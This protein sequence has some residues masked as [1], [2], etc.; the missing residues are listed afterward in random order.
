ME[1][2]S[3][4]EINPAAAGKGAETRTLHLAQV[5]KYGKAHSCFTASGREAI[6]LALCSLEAAQPELPKRC[7]LPAYLCDSVFLPFRH[8]GWELIFYTVDRGLMSYGEELFH[9]ALE[10]DPGMVLIHPYYGTDTCRELRVHLKA[11][12]KS[13]IYVMEDV[14]QSYYLEGVGKDVDFVV[15]SLRKWYAIPDGGF[16]AADIPLAETELET[17]ETSA[18]E[19]LSL[20]TA[21][22]SYLNDEAFLKATEEERQAEKTAYL[23]KNRALEEALDNYCGI[24]RMSDISL[25]I[26][27]ETDEAAAARKRAENY[28]YLYEKIIKMK[29][30]RPIL[31][32]QGGEAPLYFPIYTREREALQSFLRDRDIYAPV[33]WPLGEENRD[34]ILGNEDYIY[35]HMLALPIDQRYGIGEMEQIGMALADYEKQRVFGI[36]ADANNIVATGHIMRC[37]TIAESLRRK[38][39]RTVFF[40]A[41]DEAQEIL[42]QAGMEQ[43]CLHSE[44]NHME[45][46]L[47]QLRKMLIQE[48]VGILLVDSYQAT[49]AYFE[50]LRGQVKL[51]CLDD[52][53]EAVY[54]V[55]LLINYNA[56]HTLFPYE[57]VYGGQSRLL[58]GTDYVPLREEFAWAADETLR[59]EFAQATDETLQ[60]KRQRK[61]KKSF[62]VLL[63]SGGGDAEN[64]LLGI[65]ER[66]V[67]RN[68][69]Q[70][71][72]FHVA[73]G[74]YHPRGDELEAFADAHA[75]VRVY[76]PCL[77]M[78]GLML[79]CDAAA[80]AAGTMLF[81]LSAVQVPTVFFQTADNQRYDSEF[82]AK[83][84]RMLYAGDI[85]QDR[86]ACLTA[87]CEGLE[88]LLRDESLRARMRE[89]LSFVTDGRGA[90][91]IAEEIARL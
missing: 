3:I 33:L 73:A 64:A 80:S 68:A 47:P 1:I 76:R 12:R 87:I 40:T 29:R 91:R 55:D 11:L 67:E 34:A 69:L 86:D 42:A 37:I 2:G 16:V 58:L 53:Y 77:D 83:E 39:F 36:R 71:V 8:R 28:E 63:A 30:V 66:A 13:G 18:K 81:E 19:R 4:F 46:E 56:Y 20:L 10:H 85:R 22:W 27:S 48:N 60:K 17:E 78:A 49:P 52:C 79:A 54:P 89:K 90:G 44:W 88:R 50:A 82:F 31:Q 84:E 75:N 41:D 57:A 7:L 43:V 32:K 25:S 24:R 45:E 26:L 61:E 14:T 38:G 5:E 6:E 51:A 59:E 74:T 70:N 72:T 21:K 62:S 9:L 35:R 65:L 15:G 23:G